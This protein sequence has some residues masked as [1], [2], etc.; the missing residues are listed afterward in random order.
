MFRKLE[1]ALKQCHEAIVRLNAEECDW[2][3]EEDSAYL[4]ADRYE[5]KAVKLC[6]KLAELKGCGASMGRKTE[7]KFK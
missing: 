5:R 4:K 2:D 1:A 6:K 3:A 7:K